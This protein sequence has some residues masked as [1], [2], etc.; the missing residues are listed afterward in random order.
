MKRV[1]LLLTLFA[2]FAFF[3]VSCGG[4][5]TPKAEEAAT[6]EVEQA[7]EA[8]EPAAEEATEEVTEEATEAAEDV[9]VNIENGKAVYDKSC[10]ACH[11]AGVAGAAKL[12][13]KAR[14]EASA[15][16]GIETLDNNAI[17]GFTGEHGVMPAKGGNATFSD[18]EVKDAVAYMLNA[19]GV[20]AE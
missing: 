18:Q 3:M 7:E 15:A 2:A 12:D 5:E 17:N 6:P 9:T 13:D 10:F 4:S 11:N 1:S 8:V 20:T 16:K 19:A 14:W